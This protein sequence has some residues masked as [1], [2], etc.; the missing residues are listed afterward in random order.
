MRT[1]ATHF[2]L[3]S[4][5]PFF[6]FAFDRAKLYPTSSKHFQVGKGLRYAGYGTFTWIYLHVACRAF[7]FFVWIFG[8]RDTKV[9]YFTLSYLSLP[10][11]GT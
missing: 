5:S 7:L 9:A 6:F 4:F 8:I 11:L 2:F 10:T 1:Y 3:F